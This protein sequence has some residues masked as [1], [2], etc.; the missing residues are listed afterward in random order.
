[1]T[2]DYGILDKQI[3]GQLSTQIQTEIIERTHEN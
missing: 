1:M 2:K 3:H